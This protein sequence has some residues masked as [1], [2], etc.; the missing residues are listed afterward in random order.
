VPG[1]QDAQAGADRLLAGPPPP[2][3]IGIW[4]TPVKKTLLISPFTPRPVKYS[5]LARKTTFLGTG[6]GPKK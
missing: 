6:S 4:P 1:R 3:S 2:R 5:A